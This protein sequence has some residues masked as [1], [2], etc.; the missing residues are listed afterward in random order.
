[1]CNSYHG[2]RVITVDV[3]TEGFVCCEY[4]VV[5]ES[6]RQARKKVKNKNEEL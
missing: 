2:L 6:K 5:E 1:M 3:V 4:F